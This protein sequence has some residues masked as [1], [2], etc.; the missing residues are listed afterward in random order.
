MDIKYIIFLDKFNDKYTIADIID[1]YNIDELD[2][3]IINLLDNKL[4]F[5]YY[6]KCSYN[7]QLTDYCYFEP[8]YI[9]DDYELVKYLLSYYGS[10]IFLVSKSIL[11][12]ELWSIAY[13]SYNPIITFIPENIYTYELCIKVLS[14]NGNNIYYIPKKFYTPE[15][16]KI[17]LHEDVDCVRFI[18]KEFITNEISDY[19]NTIDKNAQIHKHKHNMSLYG[20]YIIKSNEYNCLSKMEI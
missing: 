9:W 19:I 14:N 13:E 6:I 18:P 20:F 2:N 15:I 11:N 7:E 16:I 3:F 17:A 4:N 8:K 5:N 10:L 12:N 1:I